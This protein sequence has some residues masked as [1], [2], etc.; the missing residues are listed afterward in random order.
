[1]RSLVF[2]RLLV[3]FFVRNLKCNWLVLP[4]FFQFHVNKQKLHL[5]FERNFLNFISHIFSFSYTVVEI[6]T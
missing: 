1:M 4:N 5:M 2:I 3:F 6:R